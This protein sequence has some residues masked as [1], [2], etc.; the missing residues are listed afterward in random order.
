M[1][2]A[3][4]P[5][6]HLRLLP[7][8]YALAIPGMALAQANDSLPASAEILA[9]HL[10]AIGGRQAVLNR[11]S[12]HLKVLFKGPF[13]S[14]DIVMSAAAP[15]RARTRW[16]RRD[17]IVRERGF[18]GERGWIIERDRGPRFLGGLELATMRQESTFHAELYD[19]ASFA[20]IETVAITDFNEQS[21]Y[22][23]RLVPK[24]GRE[25][26]DYF[27]VE[28]GLKAGSERTGVGESFVFTMYE[29]VSDYRDF[30]GVLIPMKWVWRY[31]GWPYEQVLTVQSVE[32][33]NVPDSV[34]APPAQLAASAWP[35]ADRLVSLLNLDEGH[36]VADVGAG[37]GLWALE[38]ARRVGPAGQVLATELN[39]A[40]LEEMRKAATHEGLT[41]VSPILVDQGYTGLS[42]QCCDRILLRFVYH[43]FTDPAVMN[44]S[45]LRALK[46]GGL[47]VVI[48]VVA[49]GEEL[50]SGRG[51]HAIVPDVLIREMVDAGFELVSKAPDYDG[52]DN[53]FAIV[54]R[55]PM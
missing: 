18:D 13:A 2:R 19:S 20:T 42:R 52:H 25:W 37:G 50:Q 32:F 31:E 1:K 49:K 30:A 8:L 24:E 29:T 16:S 22:K 40:L 10:E 41:N 11:Q 54:L 45:M 27:D 35:Y 34:F 6:Y 43:E 7:A 51:N 15:N 33:D 5:W 55:R 47:I 14:F 21:C 9:R 38:L 53:R 23:V 44:P 26:F 36:T 46:P 17:S 4:L 3:R 48:D 39:P 12:R 28:T